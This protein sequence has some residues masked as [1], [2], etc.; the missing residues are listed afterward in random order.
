ML[1][2]PLYNTTAHEARAMPWRIG[3]DDAWFSPAV[4]G[5]KI[6]ITAPLP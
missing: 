6:D 1:A 4:P 2:A 5:E 3:D